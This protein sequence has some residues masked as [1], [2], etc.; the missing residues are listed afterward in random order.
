MQPA[1]H[2]AKRTERQSQ[3]FP[4]MLQHSSKLKKAGAKG[5]QVEGTVEPGPLCHGCL[6]ETLLS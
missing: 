1:I 5:T 3:V 2:D 6:A 4:G